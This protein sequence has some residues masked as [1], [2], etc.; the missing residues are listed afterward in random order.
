MRFYFFC[1]PH[2]PA[3]KA[4]YEHQLLAI[5]E[6]LNHLGVET[7]GNV[8]YWKTDPHSSA[9]QIT[10]NSAVCYSDCDAV[11]F[12]STLY[13]YNRQ[14]LLPTALFRPTRRYKLIFVD[15]ADGIRT[16]GFNSELRSVDFVLKTHYC[17][18]H[19]YPSNFKPWQF[20]LTNR[21]ITS[22]KPLPFARRKNELLVNFRVP[23]HVRDLAA[24]I[25]TP[26]LY[27]TLIT[28]SQTDS[29]DERSF[30]QLDQ[31]FWTQTGRRHYP[32]FYAR[33][34]S[35]KACAAFGGTLAKPLSES[36]DLLSR[37][38]R[39]IDA[40]FDILNYDRIYQFDSWRFWE[41]LVSGCVTLH[42]D[43]EKY[44]AVL[45]VM[46]ENRKH[47]LGVDFSR[48]EQS[49]NDLRQF[50]KYEDIAANAR[51]WAL[52]NYSPTRVAE[53]ILNLIE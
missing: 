5:A 46:P 40:K 47:Y 13:A 52:R 36:K 17:Q 2:G 34:G 28:N 20:G 23:H 49:V 31:L 19:D 22:V 32:E 16:P 38:V 45:P 27:P 53:R 24:K 14:D 26:A 39:R 9:F 6:G 41:S 35:S 15:S 8:D 37:L 18:K 30:S 4:G 25:I 7:Y 21:I 11:V 43:L 50:D 51:E 3:D 48:L 44:G 29:F 33:L 12:S 1:H 10:S 42:V